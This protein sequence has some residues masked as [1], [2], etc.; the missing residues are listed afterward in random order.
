MKRVAAAAFIFL[1]SFLIIEALG[2]RAMKVNGTKK[3]QC[4]ED[5]FPNRTLSIKYEGVYNEAVVEKIIGDK[6]VIKQIDAENSITKVY[7]VSHENIVLIY[8]QE[9]V[10]SKVDVLNMEPNRKEVILQAA[11]QIGNTWINDDGKEYQITGINKRIM[12]SC[13]VYETVE[14]TC[15]WGEFE[16]KSYYAAG[17]GLIRTVE[18]NRNSYKTILEVKRVDIK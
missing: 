13:G 14:V 16:F 11:L 7:R 2:V 6:I 10:D 4:P 1:S 15:K 8:S 17:V 3:D 18:R 9:G 12:T 5:Y